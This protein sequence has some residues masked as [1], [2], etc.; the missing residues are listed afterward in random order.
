MSGGRTAVRRSKEPLE[1]G[2][3]TIKPL[4]EPVRG[5]IAAAITPLAVGGEDLDEKAILPLIDFYVDGGL[6]G[7]LPLGTTGEGILLTFEERCRA[8]SAFVRA[9]LN[10]LSVIMHCGAQTTRDTVRLAAHAAD[11]GADGVA[12]IGPPYFPLDAASLTEHFTR[13][14]AACS[15]LPF[16]LY[17]F[18][19]RA[20]YSIPLQVLE[21]VRQRSP[22][23][24]GL[25]VSNPTWET[26]EPYLVEGLDVFVGSEALIHRAIEGGAAGAVS[27]LCG[28]LPTLVAE[29]VRNPT[30]EGAANL[31][32]VRRNLQAFPFH[33]ALKSILIAQGLPIH[34]DVRAPLRALDPNESQR[35]RRLLP[36]ILPRRTHDVGQPT[37]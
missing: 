12:V 22:N 19:A 27:G 23:L 28:A 36:Q 30:K 24:R 3:K 32:S 17:E 11:V 20:G 9:A 26:V 7:V 18:S 4:S 35:L 15:P 8:G 31:E 29:V 10:R 14:A 5:T 34:P 2:R 16:Y 13:A 21:Q 33:A 6:D 25:K 37:Q 1:S